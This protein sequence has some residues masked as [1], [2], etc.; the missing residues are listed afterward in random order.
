[1]E[2]SWDCRCS[3][4]SSPGERMWWGCFP[5]GATAACDQPS[6]SKCLSLVAC[7]RRDDAVDDAYLGADRDRRRTRLRERAIRAIFHAHRDAIGDSLRARIVT[8]VGPD[9]GRHGIPPAPAD[10]VVRAEI[11]SHFHDAYR[12]HYPA[13]GT[14]AA[15]RAA[16]GSRLTAAD[17]SRPRRLARPSSGCGNPAGQSEHDRTG[18]HCHRADDDRLKPYAKPWLDHVVVRLLRCPLRGANG[19]TATLMPERHVPKNQAD[20]P[21]AR[22]GTAC[23]MS[24]TPD[25]GTGKANTQ[26]WKRGRCAT[27]R[28]MNATS[29][30]CSSRSRLASRPNTDLPPWA[31]SPLLHWRGPP[32]NR[33]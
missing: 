27:T 17:G 23:C 33:R 13:M 16:L 14:G 26:L 1:M 2:S 22:T 28:L 30:A 29:C 11:A 18:G 31:A 19:L 9:G 8:T 5:G 21:I 6:P 15:N 3:E 32:S 20:A 7:A 24:P 12:L 10:L 25:V 4:E